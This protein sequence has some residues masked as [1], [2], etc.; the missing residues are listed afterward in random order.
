MRGVRDVEYVMVGIL[1]ETVAF[2]SMNPGVGLAE[3][4]QKGLIDR[5]RSLPM[6]RSAV[7]AGR[8]LADTLRN[9]FVII[10]MIVVGSLVGFHLH[11]NVF[12]LMAAVILLLVFGLAMSWVMALVGLATNNPDAAQAA[13]VPLIALPA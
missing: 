1:V 12:G 13:P 9:L 7:L 4:L 2:G 3:D 6:A 8:T 10:L 5:F 11:T